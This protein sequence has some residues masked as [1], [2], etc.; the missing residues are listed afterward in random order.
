MP[1]YLKIKESTKLSDISDIIGYNNTQY[2]LAGNNL[3][4]QPNV[5]KQF[6]QLQS[7]TIADSEDVTWQRKSTILNTL[8]DSTDVFETASLMS[9]SGWK[10]LSNLS[11][12]P[13]TLKIPDTIEVPSST[14]IIGDGLPIGRRTYEEAINGLTTP[15][16][17]IDPA[18]FNEYSTIKSS[19]IIDSAYVQTVDTF[20]YFNIPWGEV[21]LYSSLSNE[22]IDFPVYPEEL[23]DSRK[24]NYNQM[25]EL[26]YQYEP[27]YVYHSSGPRSNS[28]KFDFHRQMWTGDE[29][30][31]KANELIRFCQAQCYV[32]FNG[33]CVVTPLVTLYVAGS[34]LIHGIMEDVSVKWDG[35][36]LSDGWYAHCELTLSITE[37]SEQALTHDSV[38]NLPL[39]G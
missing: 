17:T 29:S 8:T 12:L 14:D 15:P 39:I 27:W 38:R 20:Q 37:I 5:G 3:Q 22:S 10:V 2:L 6:Y 18:I 26:L 19:Q 36:I 24:A 30:D 7:Q 31:G 28:Y 1:Q 4:W 21:T 34:S 16:H 9:E 11:T 33:S 23:E 13:N 25:T 32:N 35:P